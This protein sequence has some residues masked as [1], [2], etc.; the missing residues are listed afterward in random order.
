[1]FVKKI[2]FWKSNKVVEFKKKCQ[3][4]KFISNLVF[5]LSNG[6]AQVNKSDL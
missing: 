3:Q 6:R 1:M 5:R 2:F 4:G